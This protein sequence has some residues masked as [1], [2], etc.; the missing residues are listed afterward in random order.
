MEIMKQT[1]LL[2][3]MHWVKLLISKLLYCSYCTAG[4]MYVLLC[5]LYGKDVL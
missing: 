4:W 5:T 2:S 3:F 1:V